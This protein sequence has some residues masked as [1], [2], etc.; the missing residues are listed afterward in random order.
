MVDPQDTPKHA[1]ELPAKRK[2]IACAKTGMACKG[3]GGRGS[4]L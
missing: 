3:G 4:Q 1:L 2:D